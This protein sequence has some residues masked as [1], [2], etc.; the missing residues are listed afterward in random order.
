MSLCKE[1]ETPVAPEKVIACSGTCGHFF[2]Q[3]CVLNKTQIASWSARVGLMWFC[4]SCRLSFN[5]A[6]YAREKVIMKALR[7]LLIRMDSMDTRL[8]AFGENLRKVNNTLYASKPQQKGPAHNHAPFMESISQLNLDT[9]LDPLERSRSCEETSFFEVIDEINTTIAH[10]PER[11]VVG[12]N[13]RVQINPQATSSTIKQPR[14]E[15]QPATPPPN[16]PTPNNGT[17]TYKEAA[18]SRLKVAGNEPVAVDE[19]AFYVT[20]FSPEQTE[21]DIMLHICDISNCD[22]SQ[23]KVV[24]LV[25]REKKLSD[26]SFVSFK[27]TVPKSASKYVGDDFYWPERVVVRPFRSQSKNGQQPLISRSRERIMSNNQ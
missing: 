23:V 19:E 15:R 11:F 26:L 17:T 20:P 21:E 25:P 12:N 13:K 14:K 4:A 16:E 10:P 24:K 3:N 5:P 2:H 9:V 1:C 7:E 27:L 22:K 6:V 18:A 8:G